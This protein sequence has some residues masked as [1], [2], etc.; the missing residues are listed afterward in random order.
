MFAKFILKLPEGNLNDEYKQYIIEQK[1]ITEEKTHKIIDQYLLNDGTL[2][3]SAM[4]SDWFPEVDADIFL[5][6]SH[7]DE[8]AIIDIAGFLFKE[9]GLKCFIDSMVWGYADKLLKQIDE[10]YC[11]K[12]RDEK[13]NKIY[14]YE[15]RNRT[16]AQVHLMLQGALAKM[17]DRCE[18]LVFVNTPQS[19]KMSDVQVDSMTAS[20]W[21]YSELLWQIHFR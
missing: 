7:A 19:L 20:P 2:D 4:E 10:K 11:I 1:R 14:S 15:N 6:H 12:S 9:C 5:S 21:I 17:I 18:C 8:K 3:A 13:G 16:T